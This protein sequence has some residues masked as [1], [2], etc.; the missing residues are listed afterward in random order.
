MEF[1]FGNDGV[2]TC[3]A[4]VTSLV[5]FQLNCAINSNIN[6]ASKKP[7]YEVVPVCDISKLVSSSF[8]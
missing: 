3:D 5:F 2:S 7:G 4:L 6:L 8:L 1:F